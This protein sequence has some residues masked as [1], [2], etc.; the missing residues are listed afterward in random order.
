MSNDLDVRNAII[1]I[2]KGTTHKG[3][4][5]GDL[6]ISVFRSVENMD[7]KSDAIKLDYDDDGYYTAAT[8]R[9]IGG[10]AYGFFRDRIN[11]FHNGLET[12]V[13]AEANVDEVPIGPNDLEIEV[14]QNKVRWSEDAWVK[15]RHKPSGITAFSEM[16]KSQHK[17]KLAAYIILR[18]KLLALT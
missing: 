14:S 16:E 18:A 12:A 1:E 9:V 10:G 2:S 7:W 11:G 15:I 8:I 3:C 6:I 4:F 5:V 17:N 13:Y